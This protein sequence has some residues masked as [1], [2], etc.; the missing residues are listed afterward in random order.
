MNTVFQKTTTGN[1]INLNTSEFEQI[2]NV[3]SEDAAQHKVM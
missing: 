1:K 2:P 3:Q